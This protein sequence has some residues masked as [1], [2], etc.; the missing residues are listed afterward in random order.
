MFY[1]FGA[2]QLESD[3]LLVVDLYSRIKLNMKCQIKSEK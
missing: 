1:E 2:A 3:T